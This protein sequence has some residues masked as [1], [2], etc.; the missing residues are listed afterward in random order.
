MANN[1][2]YRLA[3]ARLPGLFSLIRHCC[4]VRQQLSTVR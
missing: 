2:I 4:P 1:E 3:K